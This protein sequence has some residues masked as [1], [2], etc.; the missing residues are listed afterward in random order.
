[1]FFLLLREKHFLPTFLFGLF[2][3]KQA[4]REVRFCFRGMVLDGWNK[5][6]VLVYS[7]WW[8]WCVFGGVVVIQWYATVLAYVMISHLLLCNIITKK[9]FHFFSNS[10]FYF[11]KVVMQRK[12]KE[13]GK[14]SRDVH[15]NRHQT[16]NTMKVPPEISKYIFQFAFHETGNIIQALVCKTWK[17]EFGGKRI[18]VLDAVVNQNMATY[19]S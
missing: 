11:G 13:K 19:V 12:W 16:M 6:V 4:R 18:H 9:I 8:S 3:F 14:E 5:C 15:H 1:M 10:D 2:R 17:T 7:T